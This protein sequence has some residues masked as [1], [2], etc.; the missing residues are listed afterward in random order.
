[1]HEIKPHAS[2][3]FFEIR[4]CS[5]NKL[6]SVLILSAVLTNAKRVALNMTVPSLFSGIFIETRR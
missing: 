5:L 3:T 4:R 2:Y 1:M 6:P